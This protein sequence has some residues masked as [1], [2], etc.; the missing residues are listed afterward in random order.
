MNTL[1]LF[2]TDGWKSLIQKPLLYIG[3]HEKDG[4]NYVVVTTQKQLMFVEKLGADRNEAIKG[5]QNFT[6][7]VPVIFNQLKTKSFWDTYQSA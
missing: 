4:I 3:F 5:I 6:N 2:N 7:G 1:N